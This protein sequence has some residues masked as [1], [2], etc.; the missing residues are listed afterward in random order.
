MK[1]VILA[2]LLL[3]QLPSAP[4]APA[5]KGSIEGV[6]IGVDGGPIA[7]VEVYAYASPAPA[8]YSLNDQPRTTSD[9]NG[10]FV[11]RNVGAGGYR[12]RA[13]ARGYASQEFGAAVAGRRGMDAGTV[14]T[15]APGEDKRGIA[16]QLLKGG[17]ISGRVT[18]TTGSP[19]PSLE[20]VALKKGFDPNGWATF[21]PEGIGET[22]DRGEYRLGGLPPGQYFVRSA[23]H[24]PNFQRPGISG[25]SPGQ[26]TPSYYPGTAESGNA[27]QVEVKAGGERRNIDF[28]V[29]GATTF[30][31]RGRIID[32]MET[33][34]N[35]RA[36]IWTTP[37]RTDYSVVVIGGAALPYRPDGTFEF[38]DIVPG[39]HWVYASLPGAPLTPEQRQMLATTPGA[40]S[41][42][43]IPPGGAA[44]VTV[45]NSDVENVEIALVRGLRL[46]GTVS[47]DG[48]SAAPAEI[49]AIKIEFH[50]II[51]SRVG[52]LPSNRATMGPDGRFTSGDLETG[53]YLVTLAS[54]PEGHYLKEG[55]LG[56]VNV[57]TQPVALT[58]SQQPSLEFVVA[59]GSEVVGTVTDSASRAVT[60]QQVVLMPELTGRSDLYKTATTDKNGRFTIQGVAPGE[61]K[62]YAWKVL[63]P[64]QYFDP[65]F[66][67]EFADKGTAVRIAGSSATANVKL[68]D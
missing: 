61:Y 29:P 48:Q 60:N 44:L 24:P 34:P 22:D 14:V 57:L 2:L 28:A 25:P 32:P 21:V 46:T 19:L 3:L 56:D 37:A 16:I 15:L 63:E 59:K 58:S 45:T 7:D 54:L 65:E 4:V 66:V 35:D 50:R 52:P 1:T 39:K 20:V 11:L 5:P 13:N 18:S 47:V 30:A 38:P 31:I 41:T 27:T 42:L 6:V 23:S 40:M 68:I 33:R 8:F 62:A 36:T 17:I 10:R 49:T 53:E 43:P 55:K 67:R 12:I 51:A 64:F 26:F 9:E